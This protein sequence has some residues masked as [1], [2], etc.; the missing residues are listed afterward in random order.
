[1][2][3]L[4]AQPCPSAPDAA[5]ARNQLKSSML[6][7]KHCAVTR[8]RPLRENGSHHAITPEFPDYPIAL[9]VITPCFP[10]A[11]QAPAPHF[12]AFFLCLLL[13]KPAVVL[14]TG[15]PRAPSAK[16]CSL[17]RKGHP[18]TAARTR[19]LIFFVGFFNR[20]N[21]LENRVESHG[22][23]LG[24]ARPERVGVMDLSITQVLR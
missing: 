16:S 22:A 7:C 6:F 17:W 24:G 4:R 23:P 19:V 5:T 2:I 9:E 8:C 12:C 18:T 10:W 11:S 20:R 21:E 14:L 13:S 3:T 1:M 15:S